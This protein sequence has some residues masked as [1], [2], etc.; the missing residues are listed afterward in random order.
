MDVHEDAAG[1]TITASFELPGLAKEDVNIDVHNNV[2]TVSGESKQSEEH[3]DH[4]FVVKERRYGK[5]S[6][7][8][9]VPQG[10]KVSNPRCASWGE[11]NQWT[12]W[13]LSCSPRISRRRWRTVS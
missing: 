10:I 3:N 9:P 4:G 2:L 5:F 1:N 6:R 8:I 13:D 11:V 7:S 12:D